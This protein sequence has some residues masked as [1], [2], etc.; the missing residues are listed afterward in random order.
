MAIFARI[1][2]KLKSDKQRP[3]KLRR[4]NSEAPPNDR[5][6]GIN[7]LGEREYSVWS[8]ASTLVGTRDHTDMLHGLAHD[9]FDIVVERLNSQAGGVEQDVA[10]LRRLHELSERNK[11][12]FNEIP[13]NIWRHITTFLDPADAAHLALTSRL[14]LEKLGNEPLDILNLPENRH[15]RIRFLNQMDAQLP[16]HLLCFPCGVYHRRTNIGNER[17]KIDYVHNPPFICPKSTSTVLPRMRLAHGRQLP[18]YFVQ[19]ATRRAAYSMHHGIKCD[20]LCRRWKDHGNGWTHQSLYMIHEGRLLLRMRSQIF[21][22]P[23]LTV[24]AQRMLL[25]DR[26]D[27][28]PFFSV[29]A[30]W[31][32]GEL[33][34]VCK[35][36]LSHVP[37]PPE[38]LLRQIRASPRAQ[39]W[40]TKPNLMARQCEFCRPARR[41]PECPTEYLLEISIREDKHDP[42]NQFKHVLVATRWSDLGDGT[43]PTAS[44]EWCAINGLKADYDS[45]SSVG[46]RAVAGTFESQ[47]SGSIPGQR[48]ISLNPKK[49]KRGEDEHGW[50]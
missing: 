14:F 19:L 20:T 8:D 43:S 42:V 29:C 17:P 11:T 48:M 32:D 5:Q 46:R 22:P 16:L 25:Y 2:R 30:H 50:Y 4:R 45:F 33:M 3:A 44:K 6:E 39:D 47:M 23:K 49:T 34:N 10:E 24:T 21:A 36:A 13:A 26:D 1:T 27:F 7:E 38:S 9:G 37:A 31:R 35:C 40:V 41:C 28:K 15:Y 12:R 18:Y